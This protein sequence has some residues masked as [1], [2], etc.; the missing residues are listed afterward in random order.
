[1]Y[2]SH[3]IFHSFPRNNTRFLNST[4]VAICC[5]ALLCCQPASQKLATGKI[6][7]YLQLE[8]SLLEI[9]EV[10]TDLEVPWDLDASE[11]GKLWFTEVSGKLYCLDLSNLEKKEILKVDDVLAKKSYGLLG[12]AVHPDEGLVFL[13]Y[14]FSVPRN[15][16]EESVMSR[17]VR[18]DILENG[19]DNR[20]ILI[21]SLPGNT[22]H[23]GSRILL[24][25]D[26]L[27]FSLGDVGKTDLTQSADFPGGKIMR[28][29][30]DGSIPADNPFP[31]NPV[32]AIGLRNTQGLTFGKNGHLFASD[33]GPI[34]DDEINLIQKG[35]NYGW[36]DVAGFCDTPAE[37]AY[38][39]SHGVTEPL[40][41]WTPTIATAGL[42]YYHSQTI[43]EWQNSLILATMKGRS[44]RVLHLNEQGN[45]IDSEEIYLQNILGRI[46][47]ISV[48]HQGEVYLSTSNRDWHPRFQPWMYEGLPEG[49]DRIIRLRNIQPQ[50]QDKG[51]P[52]YSRDHE[53]IRLMDENWN[54]EVP[55]E[56]TKGRDLYAS[57]CLACHGP[58]GTGA[59]DLIPPLSGAP[60]VTGDKGR[61]IRTMLK[62]LNGE[63]EVNG[64]KYNQEM[65]AFAHLED[66]DLAEILTFIRNQFGNKASAVIPGEVFEERKGVK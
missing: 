60:W 7:G 51:L 5:I 63:I 23:N 36:P 32:W 42:E 39:S 62:G 27:Y 58:D 57:H 55:A 22:F 26:L 47:D 33:H 17:L 45:K 18:Y 30:L 9:S 54:P 35:G 12:M 43:P 38:C 10:V 8:N 15:G 49:P 6:L 24:D 29:G 53:P 3:S 61:L 28:I 21:D 40:Q 1:M 34:N 16:N 37:A 59:K 66:S 2:M 65:P 64:K 52:V 56:L 20:K 44:I 13:H 50:E 41:A 31:N 14:T 48:G 46:R 25:G 19:L 4:I 11:P